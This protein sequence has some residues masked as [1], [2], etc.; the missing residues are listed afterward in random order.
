[1]ILQ[2]DRMT[3]PSQF[4]T[5]D[6]EHDNIRTIGELLPLVLARYGVLAMAGQASETPLVPVDHAAPLS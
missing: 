2:L 1:M 5:P 3:V 6:R 4:S